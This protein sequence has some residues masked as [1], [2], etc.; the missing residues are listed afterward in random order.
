MPRAFSGVADADPLGSVKPPA[1]YVAWRMPAAAG[2]EVGRLRA[3]DITA[4]SSTRTVA[5]GSL[6]P[7]EAELVEESTDLDADELSTLTS[8]C[9]VSTG[10]LGG[11]GA[12]RQ[13]PSG[14]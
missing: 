6:S 12:E 9:V 8:A 1:L 11:A 2:D 10:R 3:A 4:S 5:G 13:P 14:A 7:I